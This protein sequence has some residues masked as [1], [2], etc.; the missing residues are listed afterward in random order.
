MKQYVQPAL[1]RTDKIELRPEFLDPV[2][3]LT[4]STTV[5]KTGGKSNA[6]SASTT[7]AEVISMGGVS[8]TS[9]KDSASS[10]DGESSVSSTNSMS[11]EITA[12]RHSSGTG[13]MLGIPS[14][15][16]TMDMITEVI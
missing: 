10:C 5:D 14:A 7:N 1:V 12:F 4:P 16:D 2:S 6:S 9:V 11:S 8:R 15:I 3:F 13:G